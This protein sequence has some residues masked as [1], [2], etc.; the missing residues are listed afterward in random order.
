MLAALDA[1]GCDVFVDVHGDECI[2]ANFFQD[3]RGIPGWTP[4]LQR[5]SRALSDAM[6]RASPDFQ[7]ELGYPPDAPA[8]A[9]M[10]ICPHQVA[11]RFDCL[12]VTLEMPFKDSTFNTP[13]PEHGWAPAR[14]MRLGGSLVRAI[15]EVLP[16]VRG[17]GGPD[18]RSD[19]AGAVALD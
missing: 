3:T 8:S 17:G 11:E 19:A 6:L 14:A 12:A 15:E 1:R 2:E 10:S 18:G 16:E 9:I 5:L 13:E 4:R 7:T